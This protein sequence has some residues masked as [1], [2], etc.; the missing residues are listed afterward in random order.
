LL[1]GVVLGLGLI[2]VR[3]EVEL[4]RRIRVEARERIGVRVV[5]GG[6]VGVRVILGYDLLASPARGGSLRVGPADVAGAMC[7]VL[8]EW[9]GRTR[10][11]GSRL[12]CDS[13]QGRR[14]RVAVGSKLEVGVLVVEQNFAEFSGEIARDFRE[15][16]RSQSPGWETW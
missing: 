7:E 15:A 9:G 13:P 8:M 16:S 2:W 11:L 12:A 6:G 1:C 14:V 3:P 5:A 10:W 4:V